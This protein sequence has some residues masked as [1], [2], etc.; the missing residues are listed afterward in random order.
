VTT[1]FDLTGLLRRAH[2][3]K[4][5]ESELQRLTDSSRAALRGTILLTTMGERGALVRCDSREDFVPARS[6]K[7]PY[8]IGAGDSFL[9]SFTAALLDGCD[10]MQGAEKA[11]RFTEDVLRQRSE[12]AAGNPMW[13]PLEHHGR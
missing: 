5:S 7:T 10:P 2:V 12:T 6:I 11:A 3:V 13:Q 1:R 9:A 8:T 4:A